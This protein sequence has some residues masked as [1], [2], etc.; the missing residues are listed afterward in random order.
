MSF[1]LL[2]FSFLLLC[3][4]NYFRKPLLISFAFIIFLFSS[5]PIHNHFSFIFTSSFHCLLHIS[6]PDF[7]IFLLLSSFFNKEEL[8]NITLTRERTV[9]TSIA[10]R[11][12][13]FDLLSQCYNGSI[14]GTLAHLLFHWF[15]KT[16]IFECWFRSDQS[17]YEA[18]Q[19]VQITKSIR[20][21]LCIRQHDRKGTWIA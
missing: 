17:S 2:F 3:F 13:G 20:S 11:P 5:P 21:A 10:S 12:C 7:F 16:H 18:S 15:H 9:N 4:K 8:V 14:E 6:L 1:L 19:K